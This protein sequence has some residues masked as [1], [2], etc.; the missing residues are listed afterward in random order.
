M[1]RL[2]RIFRVGT[3]KTSHLCHPGRV[4]AVVFAL[5]ASPLFVA[6]AYRITLLVPDG[7]AATRSVRKIAVFHPRQAKVANVL[8]WHQRIQVK[9]SWFDW[10]Q[11][12]MPI[13][14]MRWRENDW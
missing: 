9:S 5:S 11:H 12:L 14:Y 6:C 7:V 4:R 3:I 1:P 10:Q 2:V 8:T 13:R